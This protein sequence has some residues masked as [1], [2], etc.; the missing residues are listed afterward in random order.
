MKLSRYVELI[1]DKENNSYI[2][3]CLTRKWFCLDDKLYGIVERNKTNID[4]IKQIHPELFS[5][6]ETEGF[7]I[8][9][10]EEDLKRGFEFVSNQYNSHQNITITIN[11][12][13]DC[14]L[15]CWYCYE[16]RQ[17]G[18]IM[19]AT[20]LSQTIS[21]IKSLLKEISI[22]SLRLS[23]FGGE[24]LLYYSKII[25]PIISSI[26]DPC[27]RSNTKLNLT[28][29]T[30]GLLLND[31]ILKDLQKFGLST[32]FQVAFDGSRLFHNK[33]KFLDNKVSCY[34]LTMTN[35]K[36]AIE[37]GYNVIVRCNYSKETLFSFLEVVEDLK[38][39][40]SK[41][42]LRF[43]FQ[44][45]WQ[46]DKGDDILDFRKEFISLLD[47]KYNI[48]SNLHDLLGNSSNR[49][50]ADYKYNIVINYDGKLFKC[51]AR[52]FKDCNSIGHI[53]D[54]GICM[55]KTSNNSD[56]ITIPY[57]KPCLNCRLLPICPTCSQARME[58]GL[59][60]C[61]VHVDEDLIIK[62]IRALFHELSKIP[63]NL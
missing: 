16:Q 29:T 12:T 55:N 23:F 35:I 57:G 44:R 43:L 1:K 60:R 33:V 46:D 27:K 63:L 2:F 48:K 14:N 59:D 9:D 3:S 28:F 11:P 25:N 34:D 31:I 19:S 41:D 13:L 37:Y 49:C 6:L 40:H 47:T 8:K 32:N 50:Y 51:T 18:S 21:Y 20:I 45:I 26:I 36:K 52:D 7:I 17:T 58:S 30:N 5:A 61:P 54:N 56:D 53:S 42:N 4:S 39:Y 15:S 38:E 22:R 10:E 24:P 62:N